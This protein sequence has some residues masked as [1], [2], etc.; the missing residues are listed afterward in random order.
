MMRLVAVFEPGS[1]GV[2]VRRNSILLVVLG[3]D[4][5]AHVHAVSLVVC[6]FFAHLSMIRAL[7]DHL[8]RLDPFSSNTCLFQIPRLQHP[9]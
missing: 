1:V 3:V 2:T 4:G 6:F 9:K 8:S 7:G 5:L